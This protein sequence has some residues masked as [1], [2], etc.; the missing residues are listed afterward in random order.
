MAGNSTHKERLIWSDEFDGPVGSPPDPAFWTH[1]TGD[2]G[3]G[4]GELQRYTAENQ[5]A[6]QDGQGNLVIRAA[7]SNAAYTS[8]RL[9]TKNR[10]EHTYGRIECR[11][12]LPKGSGVWSA[13]WALG[14]NIDEV[15]WPLCGEID[16]LEN[17]GRRPRN[18]FGTVHCPGHAKEDGLTASVDSPHDLS[19]AFHAYAVFWREDS[20]TWSLDGVDYHRVERQNLEASS[21]V[22]DH[23]FYLLL[24]VAVGGWLGGAPNKDTEFPADL[25]VDNVRWYALD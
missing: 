12:K 5:N 14:S 7:K 19:E 10:F 18:I 3:W 13:F 16:I 17:V 2:G 22:F 15:G 6:F 21:W 11:A 9:I 1:E 25:I 4:N 8:A 23:P 20:I 24:N